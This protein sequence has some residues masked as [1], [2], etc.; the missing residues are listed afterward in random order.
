MLSIPNEWYCWANIFTDSMFLEVSKVS[1]TF[2]YMWSLKQHQPHPW[3]IGKKSLIF[4]WSDPSLKIIWKLPL[5]LKIIWQLLKMIVFF[6]A[7][8]SGGRSWSS[9]GSP[10]WRG[11]RGWL[12][13]V[14][15]ANDQQRRTDFVFLGIS[16]EHIY[17]KSSF[18]VANTLWQW[19]IFHC[20][21][22][23]NRSFV[24]NRATRVSSRNFVT[25]VS[26]LAF[27]SPI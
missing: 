19:W 22:L 27:L 7:Q 3:L 18:F 20:H 23:K 12:L 6:C 25:I 17:W 26:K 10:C 2:P 11:Q 13:Q 16:I 5:T 21:V 8:P 4:L 9:R 15:A 1:L 14:G 24:I